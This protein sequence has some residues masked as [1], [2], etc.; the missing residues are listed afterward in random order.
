MAA[1]DNWL[2]A[3]ESDVR[4]ACMLAE[5]RV[6]AGITQKE[7]GERLHV[8]ASMIAKIERCD[9]LA[10]SWV[11]YMPKVL[12]WMQACCVDLQFKAVLREAP[13]DRGANGP[14]GH[15][16]K[17]IQRIFEELNKAG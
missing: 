5:A 8:S 12:A 15:K 10:M 1:G 16:G 11:R 2:I 9:P 13:A 6:L 7:M 4:I 3:Q 14:R 17:I